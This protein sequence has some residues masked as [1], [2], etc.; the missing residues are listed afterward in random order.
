M[1]DSVESLSGLVYLVEGELHAIRRSAKKLCKQFAVEIAKINGIDSK[2][3][4]LRSF[5]AGGWL[6]PTVAALKANEAH[7]VSE[8][9]QIFAANEQAWQDAHRRKLA[10]EAALVAGLKVR[11]DSLVAEPSLERVWGP[12]Q[13][14]RQKLGAVGSIELEAAG[15]VFKCRVDWAPLVPV[16]FSAWDKRDHSDCELL[17][18]VEDWAELANL[19]P[20][21]P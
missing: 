8:R 1:A 7:L 12:A 10:A 21:C 19:P 5:L 14:F 11:G 16:R 6:E 9:A 15:F 2:L 13:K 4:E 17:G 20:I 18:A 3:S